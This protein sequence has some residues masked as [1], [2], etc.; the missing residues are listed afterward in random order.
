MIQS[1]VEDYYTDSRDVGAST[2]PDEVYL[3]DAM[4]DDEPLSQYLWEMRG[5]KVPI[6]VPVIGEK[7]HFVEM[8]ISNARL[9]LS[10][11]RLAKEKA[12]RERI[13]KGVKELKE[14]LHRERLPRTLE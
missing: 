8:A 7:R 5:L 2:I 6:K 12:E 13:Q 14:N 4:E 1:F 9:K 3:S 11:R 10:E